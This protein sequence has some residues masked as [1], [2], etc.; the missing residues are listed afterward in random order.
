[1]KH[2]LTVIALLSQCIMTAQTAPTIGVA[3]PSY[4]LRTIVGAESYCELYMIKNGR[5]RS[6]QGMDISGRYLF[7]LED[8]GHCN[9]YDFKT[10]SPDPV[11]SFELDSSGPD[12]HCNCANFGIERA[13]YSS[14]P[15]L[16]VSN[17]KV[18]GK[19]E[20]AC[21]V[22]S[23]S[24][25]K[26]VFSSIL[27]QTLILDATGFEKSG[28]KPIFGVP[29]WLVDKEEK[30]LWVLS[31]KQR[32]KPSVTKKFSDNEYIVTKFRIPKL[33]EGLEVILT[34]DDVLDQVVFDF[35]VYATQGGCAKNGKIYYSFGFG[36]TGTRTP[37]ALRVYDTKTGAISV[38][39]DLEGTV[40]EEL[41]DIAIKG[42]RMYL[43]TNSSKIYTIPLNK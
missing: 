8:R 4:E 37:S 24:F 31:A 30:C 33:K 15:L 7:V 39:Y 21:K 13:R 12:N 19:G 41:E 22:E 27:A 6:Q 2:F 28:F 38:R 5:G 40:P 32:T 20:W 1:M 34:S 17:G 29:S 10:K 14:F 43:N 3:Q 25:K 23:I 9:V 26:G 11:G 36:K 35:D 42:N 16:Y 18:G